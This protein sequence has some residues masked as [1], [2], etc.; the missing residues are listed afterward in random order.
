MNRKI[1]IIFSV[2]L[3][4]II[5]MIVSVNIISNVATKQME[6]FLQDPIEFVDLDDIEDG[7]YSGE[8]KTIPISVIVEV[9]VENHQMIEIVIVKHRSGQ[10]E[11][12]DAII[13][14]ILLEQSLDVDVVAGA[15]YSSKAIVIAI[16]EALSKEPKIR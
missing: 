2:I 9:V 11:A 10:G 8:V 14:N 7:L 5:L 13:D 4:F 15:T 3:G 1:I 16:N 6:S 12:A